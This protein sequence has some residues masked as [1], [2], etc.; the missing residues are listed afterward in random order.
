M[1]TRQQLVTIIEKASTE[2]RGPVEC[3]LLPER[4][5]ECSEV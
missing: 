3:D 4:T 2:S 5:D 1:T